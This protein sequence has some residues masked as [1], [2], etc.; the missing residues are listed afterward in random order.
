MAEAAVA[1]PMPPARGFTRRERRRLDLAHQ[2]GFKAI[3]YVCLAMLYAPILVLA[4]FSFNENRSVT[5]WTQFSLKWFQEVFANEHIQ[6]SAM[7]SLEIATAATIGS[8]I[9]ATLAA[10]ATTRTTPYRGM[11][12]A[13]IIINLPLMVPEI[14]T[15]VATLVFFAAGRVALGIDLAIFNLNLIL[16][17][18]VFCIPF[19]YLPIRARL[20]DMDRTLEQAAA[21]LYATPRQAFMRITLPLLTPGIIAGAM[22]A[23]IVS[24][25]DF[26]ISQLVAGPGQ[27][28]LPIY[29]WGQIRRGITPATNSVS[30]ILLVVSILFVSLVFLLGQRRRR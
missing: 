9:C 23:F 26:T 30:T 8:T 12:L 27:T 1:N 20:A 5:I 13:Y 7:L 22:L 19:A 17:H 25:D 2:P 21:D 29:I 16:A 28:T 3:A 4:V 15:A 6:A 10:L 11:G 24:I 18:M 14:V